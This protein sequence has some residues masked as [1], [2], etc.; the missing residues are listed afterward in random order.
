MSNAEIQIVLAKPETQNYITNTTK[1][2]MSNERHF[3]VV[4]L[5]DKS[6]EK[7]QNIVQKTGMV[8]MPR[9]VLP[10]NVN[11]AAGYVPTPVEGTNNPYYNK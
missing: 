3:S 11:D 2:L 6:R 4:V 10:V 9:E 8:P 1:V 7:V 5:K